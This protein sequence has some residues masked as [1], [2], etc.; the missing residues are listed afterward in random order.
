MIYDVP[1]DALAED[2]KP[3]V[4]D[5]HKTEIKPVNI[6][7]ILYQSTIGNRA[8]HRTAFIGH[9]S[10]ARNGETP[11]PGGEVA[12]RPSDGNIVEDKLR[13]IDILNIGSAD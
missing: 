11:P 7:C 10:M 13:V 2:P 8:I 12:I 5:P 3:M 9:V 1:Y 4:I 6:G